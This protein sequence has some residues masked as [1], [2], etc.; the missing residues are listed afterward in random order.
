MYGKKIISILK[1]ARFSGKG[2]QSLIYIYIYTHV[3]RIRK[4]LISY[5]RLD[6]MLYSINYGS[7][8]WMLVYEIHF[9][10]S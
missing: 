9:C 7:L 5:V 3:M 6:H 8:Q 4:M 1:N 10:V 2:R